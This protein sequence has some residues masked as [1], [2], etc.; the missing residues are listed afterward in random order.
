MNKDIP[1]PEVKNVT[2]VI[3][4]ERD[5]EFWSVHIVN[6]NDF[7]VTSVLVASTGYAE[8]G[9]DREKTSTIRHSFDEIGAKSSVHVELI[10]PKV[11]HLFNEYSVTYYIDKDIYYKKFLFVPDS[12]INENLSH[13]AILDAEV[14]EHS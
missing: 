3:S 9:P 13:N 7:P 6:I 14:V 12:I 5:N 4:P 1:K 2:V 11:F 8:K 10:D